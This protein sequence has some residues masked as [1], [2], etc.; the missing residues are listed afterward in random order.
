MFTR[1]VCALALGSAIGLVGCSRD[2]TAE[3][4]GAMNTSNAQRLSNMYAAYQNFKGGRGP[5]SEAEFRE[6]IKSYDP[7]KLKMMNINPDDLDGL[8]KSESDGKPF[9]VRY[10]VG[11]GRGSQDPVVFEQE[12]KDGKKNVGYT[13]GLV[14]EVDDATYKQLLAG[15]SNKTPPAGG[16]PA[17]APAGAGAKG[18]PTGPPPGAPTG[19]P[20]PGQ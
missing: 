6:F 14:E 9:K 4:V 12:G 1:L 10:N 15:K 8:F 3:A 17:G 7:T 11:G 16:P 20:A 5:A 18:R 19:P 2:R 13:G